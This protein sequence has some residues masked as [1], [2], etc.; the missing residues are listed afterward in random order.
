MLD[1]LNHFVLTDGNKYYTIDKKHNEQTAT[2]NICEAKQYDTYERANL[3]L[4]SMKKTLR[5]SD[6]NS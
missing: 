6:E 2:T 5:I 1:D 4:K 3:A